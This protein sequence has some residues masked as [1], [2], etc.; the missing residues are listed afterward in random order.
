M[1][2]ILYSV[3]LIV[4]LINVYKYRSLTNIVAL[5]VMAIAIGMFEYRIKRSAAHKK[6]QEGFDQ[7]TV[8]NTTV[9]PNDMYIDPNY[10]EDLQLLRDAIGDSKKNL[11]F[12]VSTFDAILSKESTLRNHVTNDITGDVMVYESANKT[13]TNMDDIFHQTNG[14]KI[15]DKIRLPN[16]KELLESFDKFTIFMYVKMDREQILDMFNPSA[17]ESRSY[18]L[19]KFDHHNVLNEK[20]NFTLF[21]VILKFGKM[22]HNPNI[23]IHIGDQWVTGYNY[24]E[25]ELFQDKMLYDNKF[26]LITL[27]KGDMENEDGDATIM[28]Y[29]DDKLMITCG[30]CFSMADFKTYNNESIGI[31]DS[32]I[33]IN[34]NE[35]VNTTNQNNPVN[36]GQMQSNKKTNLEF[37]LNALGVVRKKAL[38]PVEVKRLYEYFTK[39]KSDLSPEMHEMYK[40]NRELQNKVDANQ[41]ILD[42]YKKTTCPFSAEVCESMECRYINNWENINEL[43]DNP[44]CFQKLNT[45]CDSLGTNI[46]E[47]QSICKY[48]KSDNIGKMARVVNDTELFRKRYNE[49]KEGDATAGHVATNGAAGALDVKDIYLDNTYRDKSGQ[50]NGEMH[51]VVSDMLRQ[52][53]NIDP[54]LVRTLRTTANVGNTNPNRDPSGVIDFDT[55]LDNV[56]PGSQQEQVAKKEDDSATTKATDDSFE[57]LKSVMQM[58][59]KVEDLAGHDQKQNPYHDLLNKYDKE[60]QMGSKKKGILDDLLNRWF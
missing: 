13:D 10:K 5:I 27:V 2:S 44:V 6:V 51:R 57:K 42:R 15:V 43:V 14:L 49:G 4:V 29:L 41:H 56:E 18:S 8:Y 37:R 19:I 46:P 36:F 25:G 55:L 53:G 11:V 30:Q 20:K 22:K 21:E 35:D 48:I 26:H 9:E 31:R 34:D 54:S 45:Y 17:P 7:S 1:K 39:I 60:T 16:A 32:D 23:D 40:S 12:Y 52:P 38:S 50:Y 3:L 59:H 47:K 58:S 24:N 28:L 33:R